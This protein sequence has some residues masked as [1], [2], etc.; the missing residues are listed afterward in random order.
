MANYVCMYV[1]YISIYLENILTRRV[2]YDEGESF[3]FSFINL[4]FIMNFILQYFNDY[5]TRNKQNKNK[6]IK[7]INLKLI[8]IRMA[9]KT[10]I[11]FF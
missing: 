8:G 4:K 9:N 7:K 1:L 2:S 6:I 10:K 11:F 5:T 3:R